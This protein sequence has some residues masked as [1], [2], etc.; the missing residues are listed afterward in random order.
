MCYG[1]T[2]VA[3]LHVH[4]EMTILRLDQEERWGTPTHSGV[5]FIPSKPPDTI[6]S[7][8]WLGFGGVMS[9]IICQ[10]IVSSGVPWFHFYFGSL[11]LSGLNATFLILSFKPT[12]REFQKERESLTGIR[13]PSETI[14]SSNLP[15]PTSEQCGL[16]LSNAQPIVPPPAN[17]ESLHLFC[18]WT[19]YIEDHVVFRTALTMPYQWAFSIFAMLYCGRLVQYLSFHSLVAYRCAHS[20]TATQGFVSTLPLTSLYFPQF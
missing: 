13:S 19:K 9:P 2:L 4:L 11:V 3:D 12:R 7:R 14:S 15:S 16:P 20:E 1:V 17:S 18:A 5:R 10:S 8:L 6:Y